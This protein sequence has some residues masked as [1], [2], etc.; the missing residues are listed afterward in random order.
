MDKTFK[1]SNSGGYKKIR[2][3][4]ADGFAG[5]SNRQM[6]K[7]NNN[8][9]K[10]KKFTARFTDMAKPK[11]VIAIEVNSAYSNIYVCPFLANGSKPQTSIYLK[12]PVQF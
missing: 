11:P 2:T 10:Y 3:R 4:A 7:L 6:L 12:K 5:L 1:K 8:N 9:I